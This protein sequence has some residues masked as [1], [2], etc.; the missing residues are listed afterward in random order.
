MLEE[1][2]L[3]IDEIWKPGEWVR[4]VLNTVTTS[5]DRLMKISFDSG[6]Y[7]SASFLKDVGDTDQTWNQLDLIM[8][9]KWAGKQLELLFTVYP[10]VDPNTKDFGQ[11]LRRCRDGGAKITFIES[12]G[13]G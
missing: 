8:A 6:N 7:C 13:D 1:V 9:N 12:L 4:E 3:D 10:S 5:N 2:K 11:F